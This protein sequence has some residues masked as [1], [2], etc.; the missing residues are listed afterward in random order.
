M[1]DPTSQPCLDLLREYA[2][3]GS[4]AAFEEVVRRYLDFVHSVALR[5]V[6]GDTHQAKDVSQRVFLDLAQQ[7]RT[8]P[9][10]FAADSVSLGGWLHRHTCFVTANLRRSE[11]RRRQREQRAFA[12]ND[13]AHESASPTTL[14]Q[15]L[16][17][18]L[19]EAVQQLTPAD[20]D[21]LILRYYE[22]QNLKAVGAA[23]G[24]S[25]DAA[26][27][28]VQRALERLRDLL[29]Q[30]GLTLSLASLALLL[31]EKTVAVTPAS[32][33][34]A[35]VQQVLSARPPALPPST[36]PAA[37]LLG[38]LGGKLAL[39]TL[40]TAM[41]AA[42]VFLVPR[43]GAPSTH[44][45]AGSD[46]EPEAAPVSAPVAQNSGARLGSPAPKAA[47]TPSNPSTPLAT[48]PSH[49]LLL[50]LLDAQTGQ[51]VPRVPVEYRGW[52]GEHFSRQRL[53]AN[54][55][56]DCLVPVVEG[57]TRLELTTRLDGYADTR[58]LWEPQNGATLPESFSVRLEK[59]VPIGGTVVNPDGQPVVGAKVG[60]NHEESGSAPEG[61][62]SQ[63]FAWVETQ[64]DAAGR[65]RIDRIG[66]SVLPLIYGSA[67][68]P[69]FESSPLTAINSEPGSLATLTNLTHVFQLRPGGTVAGKVV[70]SQGHAVAGATVSLGGFGE[71][72]RREEKSLA[73]GTFILRGGPTPP[74]L[75]TAVGE[76]FAPTTISVTPESVRDPFTLVL[77][78]GKPLRLRVVD[79]QG[80]PIVGAH[81]W[82]DTM[83]NSMR[84]KPEWLRAP[85]V[86]FDFNPRSD[87]EGRAVWQ[88]APDRELTFDVYKPGYQRLIQAKV[89]PG[90]EEN[91]LT[92]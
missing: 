46:R 14:W 71:S 77:A 38:G 66:A 72:G 49:P 39:A 18:E 74:T 56:G 50:S 26:Q 7:A 82:L 69:E 47:A 92:L 75:L 3:A 32:V 34:S 76:G 55:N 35:V 4:E 84:G 61:P 23:L 58:I 88:D 80:Q 48:A 25:D 21:S 78:P 17:P 68:H 79:T 91:V 10:L 54:T 64:T 67:Q 27:K 51:P 86:Q 40:G 1:H 19:D 5:R 15:D 36:P 2:H 22:Q 30:Q 20:R 73:D 29:V 62:V 13:A 28:R 70:D 9:R 16:A 53:V 85:P 81:V 83:A 90:K 33:A 8:D 43:F 6:D 59:P 44:P 63:R 37:P 45:S 11:A 65:W 60:F 87:A 41:L 31:E 89:H 52:E 24:I 57:T 42:L 12:M